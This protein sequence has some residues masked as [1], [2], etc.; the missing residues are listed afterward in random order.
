[1]I[2]VAINFVLIKVLVI[3]MHNVIGVE[4][5]PQSLLT[6]FCYT[7]YLTMDVVHMD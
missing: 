5:P 1:M 2:V 7:V 6:V 3:T 4:K